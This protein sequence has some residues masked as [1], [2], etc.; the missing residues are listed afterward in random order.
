M[1]SWRRL[2]LVVAALAPA[3]A[4]EDDDIM[5]PQVIQAIDLSI[6]DCAGLL[7]DETCQLGVVVRATDGTVLTDVQLDWNTPDFT[8]A[9]VDFQGRV[10]GVREGTA[11]I[12]AKSAPGPSSVCQQTGVICDS[13][14]ISVDE[15]DP[16]PGPQP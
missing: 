14:T 2:V 10:T 8:V 16:G 12:F 9:T 11:T 7:V 5:A 15:P 3:G 4:C 6:G 13:L 1:R